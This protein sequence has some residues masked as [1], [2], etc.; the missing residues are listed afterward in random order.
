MASVGKI[1]VWVRTSETRKVGTALSRP[2]PPGIVFVEALAEVA[3]D[4]RRTRT[5]GD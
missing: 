1:G 2:S 3:R 5:G 4:D